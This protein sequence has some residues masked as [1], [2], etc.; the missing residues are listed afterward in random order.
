[1]ERN[2]RAINVF[3]KAAVSM[4]T[5]GWLLYYYQLFITPNAFSYVVQQLEHSSTIVMSEPIDPAANS[6]MIHST[7]AP[8]GHHYVNV[9]V[10]SSK[11]FSATII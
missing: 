10:A 7:E 8:L 4:A 6:A 2:H 9:N 3:Q 1:M 11:Q 5:V